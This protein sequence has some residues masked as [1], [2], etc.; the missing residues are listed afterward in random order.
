ML[1]PRGEL[2]LKSVRFIVS[3]L[4]YEI[5]GLEETFKDQSSFFYISFGT[6]VHS[7]TG[8]NFTPSGKL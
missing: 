1:M 6:E 2:L 8:L 3:Y 5:N 7:K 4:I